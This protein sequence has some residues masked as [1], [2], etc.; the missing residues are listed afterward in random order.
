MK[1][2]SEIGGAVSGDSRDG[3]PFQ[4]STDP[5]FIFPSPDQLGCYA[6]LLKVVHSG[7]SV[8][9]LI[10]GPGTGKSLFL[11][12]LQQDLEYGGVS[13][14]L[15]DAP[16]PDLD[17]FLSKL[18]DGLELELGTG[19]IDERLDDSRRPVAVLLDEGDTIR[20]RALK[21]IVALASPPESGRPA[22]RVVIAGQ[23]RLK[24]RLTAL[25]PAHEQPE[26]IELGPLSAREIESYIDYKLRGHAGRDG[27]PFTEEAVSCIVSISGGIPGAINS[28]CASSLLEADVEERDKVTGDLVRRI[29][30]DLGYDTGPASMD[31]DILDQVARNARE[32]AHS[33]GFGME[34]EEP[35][36]DPAGAVQEFADETDSGDALTP[37]SA[38]T[39]PWAPDGEH[40]IEAEGSEPR[41]SMPLK[42]L[43]DVQIYPTIR[44][45]GSPKQKQ[46]SGGALRMITIATLLAGGAVAWLYKED[47][48][49]FD[50]TTIGRVSSGAERAPRPVTDDVPD[51]YPGIESPPVVQAPFESRR[52]PLRE[53]DPR[54]ENERLEEASVAPE[55]AEASDPKRTVARFST[56]RPD[57][58]RTPG[59]E[60]GRTESRVIPTTEPP[61]TVAAGRPSTAPAPTVASGAESVTK[62]ATGPDGSQSEAGVASA[63]SEPP[64]LLRLQPTVGD[65]DTPTTLEIAVSPDAAGDDHVLSV[66]GLPSGATLSKGTQRGGSWRISAADAASLQLVPP[67]DYAGEFTLS[68][69][70]HRR[71]G[72]DV[73]ASG[74]L[75]VV[76]RAVADPPRLRAKASPGDVGSPIPLE[77]RAGTSDSDGSE[78]LSIVIGGVPSTARL[79]KGVE[80]DGEWRL[81]PQDLAE[82]VLTPRRGTPPLVRLSVTAIA[83]ESASGDSAST[84]ENLDVRVVGR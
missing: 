64:P 9:A 16:F 77:I 18:G 79:S 12:R 59:P 8:T 1:F 71:A 38:P 78:R 22:L 41:A 52:G 15:F 54:P 30:A 49:Y 37:S 44:R 32:T 51:G 45:S 67:R 43:G 75:P 53:P 28:L 56:G 35:E 82:L 65:E 25:M 84:T 81:R 24:R 80:K 66:S 17:A 62:A 20:D 14:F 68:L 2:S 42:P 74:E 13:V 48:D 58:A 11:H 19:G 33:L 50:A 72:G 27:S 36:R 46:G 83:T 10:G 31:A 55:N 70:L 3:T 29:A 6:H 73:L 76:I 5:R 7:K 21:D 47:P 40:E 69:R 4:H 26:I 34:S 60:A 57:S 63:K 23:L 61:S 39:A